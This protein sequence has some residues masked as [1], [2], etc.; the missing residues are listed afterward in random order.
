MN[1]P[2]QPFLFSIPS[3]I[4]VVVNRIQ[5]DDWKTTFNK[6]GW[7]WP[8]PKYLAIGAGLG[9]IPGLLYFLLPNILPP[10]LMDQPGIAQSVYTGWKL[11]ILTF[12]LAFLREAVYVALGEEIL[13]RGFLGGILF[14]KL[15]FV[16][17]NLIQSAVFLLPHLLL[18]TVSGQLWPLLIAQFLGGWLF[19]W[20]LYQSKS[21][22]PSWLAH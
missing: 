10:D 1:I 9:L 16:H 6:V 5:K 19:G 14:R 13:F 22:L 7:T 8:S 20:L 17:G 18:L 2:L 15:G 12:T 21:I 11:S 3:T 4:L